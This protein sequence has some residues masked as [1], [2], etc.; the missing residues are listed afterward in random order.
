MRSSSRGQGAA[1]VTPMSVKD[2]TYQVDVVL[3]DGSTVAVRPVRADD[4]EAMAEFLRG[5][6]PLSY[7][8]RFF[9]LV[10]P[11]EMAR[12][13]VEVD[14]SDVYGL[15]AIT[16][17]PARVVGHAEFA[18]R[19]GRDAAEIAFAV[20]EDLQG[21]GLGTLLL[22][23]LAERAHASGIEVFHAE[24]MPNN[25]RM[26][27]MFKASGF[28][29]EVRGDEDSQLVRFPTSLSPGTVAAFAQRGRTAAVAMAKRLLAPASV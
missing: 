16:G 26:I 6:S 15:V 7:R 12:R 3:R 1:R 14:G 25:H 9:G 17:V 23:H 29:V 27:G 10:D 20:A 5:L 22:A 18:R 8:S 28:P 2:L 13:F 4:L 11:D 19:P 24:V 21:R